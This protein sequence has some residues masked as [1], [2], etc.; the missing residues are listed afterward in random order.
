MLSVAIDGMR[1]VSDQL[2]T[3]GNSVGP[4]L[5]G[6][7]RASGAVLVK[8]LKSAAPRGKR[9]KVRGQEIDPGLLASAQGMTVTQD[10]SKAYILKVGLNVGRSRVPR[11][12]TPIRGKSQAYYGHWL[13]LNTNERFTGEKTRT[14]R[15]KGVKVITKVA[16]GKQRQYRGRIAGFQWV[17]T[18]VTGSSQAA[19]EAGKNAIDTGIEKAL[20]GKKL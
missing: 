2:T 20:A 17:A 9:R 1:A 3:L 15:I 8:S 7:A 10:S 4:I 11:G 6:G 16:T 13:A 12:G 18:A 14:R 5:R 19:A